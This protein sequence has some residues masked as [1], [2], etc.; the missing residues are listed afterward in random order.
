MPKG[1]LM[2]T[3]KDVIFLQKPQSSL[4]NNKI[5]EQ[6]LKTADKLLQEIKRVRNIHE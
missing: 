4:K 6:A 5:P 1:S 3:C 2:M